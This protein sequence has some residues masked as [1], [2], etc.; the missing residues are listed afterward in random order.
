L[1]K[2]EIAADAIEQQKGRA[3]ACA[4]YRD[5]DGMTE[6]FDLTHFT[7]DSH[8]SLSCVLSKGLPN[9]GGLSLCQR[10]IEK[11]DRVLNSFDFR[12]KGCRHHVPSR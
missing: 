11:S 10:L 1:Q 9:S 2:F 5:P 3:A 7:G 8:V 12:C 4:P 6:N